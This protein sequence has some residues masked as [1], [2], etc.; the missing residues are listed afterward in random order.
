M[1]C[2]LS[3]RWNADITL[4]LWTS[5]TFKQTH[6]NHKIPLWELFTCSAM[7]LLLTPP[8]LFPFSNIYTSKHRICLSI[9]Y[10]FSFLVKFFRL[11]HSYTYTDLSLLSQST[12]N[13]ILKLINYDKNL[14]TFRTNTDKNHSTYKQ[15]YRHRSF[16]PQVVCTHISVTDGWL[17]RLGFAQ[18]HY[19]R[20]YAVVLLWPS[21]PEGN[22]IYPY[23]LMCFTK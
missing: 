5:P 4:L 1:K 3:R 19:H 21:S 22:A 23:I 18:T 14:I 13:P 11:F 15:T 17:G 9:F 20:A 2:S 16:S 7:S 12:W 6:W 8:V 10:S